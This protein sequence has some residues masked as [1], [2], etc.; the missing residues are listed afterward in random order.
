MTAPGSPRSPPASPRSPPASPRKTPMTRGARPARLVAVAVLGVAS[1]AATYARL[2]PSLAKAQDIAAPAATF[3]SADADD[4]VRKAA[5]SAAHGAERP[6]DG[7]GPPPTRP[8]RRRRRTPQPPGRRGAATRRPGSRAWAARAPSGPAAPRRRCSL[9]DEPAASPSVAPVLPRKPLARTTKPLWGLAHAPANDAVMGLAF[10]YGAEAYRVFVGSLRKAGFAGDVV[11]ATSEAAKMRPGV[12]AYLRSQ[13]VLAYG[14]R[15]SCASMRMGRRLLGTPGGCVLL[16]WYAAGDPRRPRPLALARYEMY[17][18][19]LRY[20]D[21]RSYALLVDTRDT[22][23]QADPFEG[24]KRRRPLDL[25]VFQ[26][27]RELKTIGRCPFNSGWLSCFDKPRGE[28]IAAWRGILDRPTPLVKKHFDAPVHCSGSTLGSRDGARRYV[29][30]MLDAFDEFACHESAF[31]AIQSDQG[32][33]NYLFLSG[34]LGA[35]VPNVTS[36]PQGFGAVN[37]IGALNGGDVPKER[38]GSLDGRWRLRH[39]VQGFVTNWDGTRSAVVHQ[40]DRWHYEMRTFVEQAF[41]TDNFFPGREP[42]YVAHPP[43]EP[44]DGACVDVAW[45]NGFGMTCGDLRPEHRDW[46]PPPR[47]AADDLWV[48]DDAPAREPPE[49]VALRPPEPR[50]GRSGVERRAPAKAELLAAN[51]DDGY[52]GDDPPPVEPRARRPGRPAAVGPE[53]AP[54]GRRAR[55]AAAR[56]GDN[57]WELADRAAAVAA[58][59]ATVP[60]RG[61][62]HLTAERFKR[63]AEARAE[64]SEASS[65]YGPPAAARNR[66]R[67]TDDDGL[68]FL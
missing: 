37:T 31:D 9:R 15:F 6:R 49:P 44:D 58:P 48:G 2:A 45:V 42:L 56:P 36:V 35:L 23:F 39:P 18:T 24:L 55:S 27:H 14:F 30:A 62:A 3:A 4:T 28:S 11:L 1:M 19:W 61:A 20:Y 25:Y 46:P 5:S 63:R 7:R 12:E 67:V 10:G 47:A 41:V 22:F 38:R 57:P 29:A 34:R 33:H 60:R 59:A 66:P 21:E 53:A 64:A 65:G 40:Y 68:R 50:V 17:A 32:Y 43:L 13:R 51:V 8:P 26:E 16:D 52:G 54:P